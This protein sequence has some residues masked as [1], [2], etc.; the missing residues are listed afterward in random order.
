MGELAFTKQ[1]ND[2]TSILG[3]RNGAQHGRRCTV[4]LKDVNKCCG[5]WREKVEAGS[6]PQTPQCSECS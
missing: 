2:G 3:G 4:L 5:S 6:R 1:G